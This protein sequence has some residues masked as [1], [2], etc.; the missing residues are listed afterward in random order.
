M[1][2][3][4]S[5]AFWASKLDRA[6]VAGEPKAWQFG[7]PH[8]APHPNGAALVACFTTSPPRR[9]LMLELGQGPES[10]ETSIRGV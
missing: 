5:V 3:A 7:W 6:A 9:L 2:E 4:G 1:G 8:P 10:P